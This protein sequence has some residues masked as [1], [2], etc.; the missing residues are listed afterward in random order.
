[1]DR[2]EHVKSEHSLFYY[3]LHKM[4]SYANR[5]DARETPSKVRLEF[6]VVH[7]FFFYKTS[8]F[9][10][11]PKNCLN[12]SIKSPQKTVLQLFTRWSINFYCL[13]LQTF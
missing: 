9:G 5:K 10:R 7:H 11:R 3:N 12:F 1:M 6:L 13:N 4:L 2:Q 8:I